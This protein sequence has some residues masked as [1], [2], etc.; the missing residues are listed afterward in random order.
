[1]ETDGVKGAEHIE[2]GGGGSGLNVTGVRLGG[3]GVAS[4]R[5]PSC[6][7]RSLLS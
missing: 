1:M 4:G 2:E 5:Y 3:K 6:I 7:D